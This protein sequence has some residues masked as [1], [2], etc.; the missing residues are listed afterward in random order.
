MRALPLLLVW[1]CALSGPL[2]AR[3]DWTPEQADVP[4]AGAADVHETTW[5]ATRPPGTTHD[6]IRLHRYRGKGAPSAALLY[7]PGTNMNG[8]VALAD[9]GHNMWLYLARRGVDVYVLDYRTHFV[10]AELESDFE[11]MRA[12]TLE[13]F[14]EDAR[15]GG[16]LARRQSGM[17][18][19][20]VAGFSRGASL[21]WGLACVEPATAGVV[22]LDG[23]FKS[24]RPSA[25]FDHAAA[26]AKLEK[27]GAW[28]SDVASGL[29]WETR[30]RLMAAAAADPTGPPEDPGFA[31]IGDQVANLLYHAWRPGGLA[32]PLDGVSR[33]Q[34]LAHLLDG[35]DRYYPAIQN[36]DNASIADHDDD[37]HTPLDDAWGELRAPVLFFGSTGMGPGFLL[38]AIY[39]AVE[40]GSR[41][42]TL[43][44]L[45]NH[46][47]L[48][49]LVGE[50][51]R[52]Q[53]FEPTLSWLRARSAR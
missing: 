28:A 10:P 45:E 6:R 30:H 48:D 46:G 15:L 2:P 26:L 5:I 50:R 36:A 24:H 21:A 47:H 39:T 49:V 13:A 29:G 51:S 35:Y 19:L 33:V 4:V 14:V 40:A 7:L 22:A 9:E 31:T 11:F 18:R 43:H 34:V 8:V 17:E 1:L 25:S 20:F 16:E 41:D 37:P 44:V 53:V 32:N 23:G 38:D 52:E 27:A 42:V 12:W 3:G